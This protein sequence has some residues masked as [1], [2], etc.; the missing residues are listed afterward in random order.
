M[1]M[2]NSKDFVVKD[3]VLRKYSGNG[4]DNVRHNT[5][6]V[7]ESVIELICDDLRF[8][9]EQNDPKYVML[10]AKLREE[11]KINKIIKKQ[12]RE[13]KKNS[14]LQN[15]DNIRRKNT[16]CIGQHRRN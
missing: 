12:K 6:A 2:S 1:A 9:D 8:K 10:N 3:G 7:A 13:Q 14:N 16:R 11:K 5:E 15:K 4:G